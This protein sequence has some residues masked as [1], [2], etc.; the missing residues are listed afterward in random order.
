M[1]CNYTPSAGLVRR[2]CFY[3][4]HGVVF[5]VCASGEGVVRPVGTEQQ[6]SVGDRWPGA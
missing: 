1:V 5:P 4:P 2:P 3:N 6:E